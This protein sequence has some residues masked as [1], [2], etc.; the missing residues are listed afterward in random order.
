[1]IETKNEYVSS[2]TRDLLL[3]LIAQRKGSAEELSNNKV[4]KR[5]GYSSSVIS[6]YLDPD[7]NK[8]PGDVV[9]LEKSVDD[10]IRNELRRKV[11]G[12]DTIESVQVKELAKALEYIR[13]TNDVGEVL[14]EA[15]VT[16][17]RAV[18]H[19][20]LANPLAVVVRAR[21]WL[22]DEHSVM[23]AIFEKVKGG[24]DNR[25]KRIDHVLK[26]LT[27]SERLIIVDDAHKL[28]RAALQ[29]CFDL[30]DETLCPFALVGI[31]E[32]EDKLADDAQRFSRVG[33]R[34]EIK[35]EDPKQL[36]DHLVKSL[37]PNITMPDQR[38]IFPLCEQVAEQHGHFRSV[39]KQ[40]KVAAE[41]R[42]GKPDIN[43]ETAFKSAHTMLVRK[44]PLN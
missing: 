16:K 5:L 21:Q 29:L 17:S 39:H 22:K 27:G 30:H 44:Y 11:S 18:D 15:G 43:W 36:S 41:I 38:I 20:S 25:T 42:E 13:K 26:K 8:Y 28:T 9:K 10:F 6:Q 33:L 24:Y 4:A 31:F 34:W 7:G 1:M 35:P 3:Q 40:L 14:S 32:L 12:V 37:C 23:Q 19:Y 2:T